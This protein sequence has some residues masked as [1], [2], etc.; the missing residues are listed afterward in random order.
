MG[1]LKGYKK[2]EYYLGELNFIE[3]V[4]KNYGSNQKNKIKVID[5]TIRKLDAT[6]G[7]KLSIQDKVDIALRSE[8]LGAN[9]IFI[10]NIHFVNEYFE[11]AK[12]IASEIENLVL[13]IQIWLTE[14]WKNGI[15]KAFEANA[16]CIEVEAKTSDLGL[17]ELGLTKKDMIKRIVTA[18]DYGKDIGAEMAAGFNDCTRA[19]PKF[20]LE[21]INE[22]LEHGASKIIL[23]DTYGALMPRAVNF[24]ITKIK[25]NMIK[26]VPIAVHFHNTFGLAT[27]CVLEAILAGA[28][29]VDVAANGLPTNGALTS[30]EEI[31]LIIDLF[32]DQ[33]TDIKLQDI[34]DYC[35]F[36]EQKTGIKNSV[37]KPLIGDHIFLYE[38]DDEVTGYYRNKENLKPFRPQRIGQEAKVVWGY[39]TLQGESIK[40]KLDEMGLKYTSGQ[41]N[42]INTKI[43]EELDKKNEFPIW[44]TEDE[45]EKICKKVINKN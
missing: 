38:T 23:Y 32:L 36:I 11:S 41:V 44:L 28:E 14:D 35:K 21:V 18:L 26:E 3:E 27:A 9:E 24:L 29:Y 4:N 39:N 12:A 43:K 10:N 25:N 45:V 5:S 37:Y 17:S 34:Y 16:D 20:L 30:L 15:N 13:N 19:D 31:S 22:S 2:G 8:K 6:P 42:I 7:I 1:K 40:A 33:T